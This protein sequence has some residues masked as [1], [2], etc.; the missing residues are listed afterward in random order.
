MYEI[1]FASVSIVACNKQDL[2]SKSGLD[3]Y[4]GKGYT[5]K[6]DLIMR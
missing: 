4:R 1:L 5:P 2:D 6:L 3:I